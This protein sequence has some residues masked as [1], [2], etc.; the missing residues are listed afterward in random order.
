MKELKF[1][2]TF[3]YVYLIAGD[4]E[5]MA[6]AIDCAIKLAEKIEGNNDKTPEKKDIVEMTGEA[7]NGKKDRVLAIDLVALDDEGGE[8]F[9][10]NVKANIGAVTP[11]MRAELAEQLAR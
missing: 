5:P 7:R 6:K 11:E 1:E 10:E 4:F 8:I 2:V 9:R 3:Y